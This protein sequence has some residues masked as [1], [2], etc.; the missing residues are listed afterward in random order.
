MVD[1]AEAERY[2]QI[3]REHRGL[4]ER[5]IEHATSNRAAF[6][7]RS[8]VLTNYKKISEE[9]EREEADYLDIITYFD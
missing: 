5:S 4:L 3:I 2:L 9:L 7:Q 1:K 8:N 6:D